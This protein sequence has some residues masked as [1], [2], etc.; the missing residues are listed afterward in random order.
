MFVVNWLLAEKV[1][2]VG[3]RPSLSEQKKPYWYYFV[4]RSDV[5]ENAFIE[6]EFIYF[7]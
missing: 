2:S 7:I 4:N 1:E 5:N 6:V 3:Y